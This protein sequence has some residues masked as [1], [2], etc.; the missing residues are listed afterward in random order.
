MRT[1][2]TLSKLISSQASY[3]TRRFISEL[4]Q[5]QDVCG[6]VIQPSFSIRKCALIAVARLGTLKILRAQDPLVG[7]KLSNKNIHIL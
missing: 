3:V 7:F 4:A 2:N 5:T 6:M 1:I